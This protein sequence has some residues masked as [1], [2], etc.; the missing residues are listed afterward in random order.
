MFIRD[1][2]LYMRIYF[3]CMYICSHLSLVRMLWCWGFL[4]VGRILKFRAYVPV[5]TQV[6][7]VINE[8]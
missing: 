2:F 8:N 1:I 3:A 5:I 6:T 4:N 7:V